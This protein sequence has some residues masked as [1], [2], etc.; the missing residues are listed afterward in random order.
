MSMIPLLDAI[1]PVVNKVLD[2]IPDPKQRA[3]A[4]AQ[5]MASLQSWDAQ[6][7]QVNAAEAA[8]SNLFVSGWRPAVGWICAAAFA[9]KFV[10]LPFLVFILIACNCSTFDPSELPELDWGEMGSLLFG[11]LGIGGM[12]TY[13]KLK[14]VD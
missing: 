13:E 14:G 2:L 10:I 6:Q 3:E 1:T 11:M 8:N 7:T 5:L 9:Y 4:Q 12:R